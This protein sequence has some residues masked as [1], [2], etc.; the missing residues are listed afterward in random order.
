[1]EDQIC[2]GDI[3]NLEA[4][5]DRAFWE[6]LVDAEGVSHTWQPGTEPVESGFTVAEQPTARIAYPWNPTAPEAE[7]FF[8]NPAIPSIFAGIE[9]AEI[10]YRSQTFFNQLQHVWTPFSV[11][12]MLLERFATRMPQ[13]WLTAIAQQAQTVVTQTQQTVADVST[14]L[15]D[16]LVQCVRELVPGLAEDDFYV[17]ARPLAVQMRD[18]SS[19]NVVDDQIAQVPQLD[20]E[21]LSELQQARLGLAIARYAIDELQATEAA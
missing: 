18:G 19:T 13:V 11:E 4:M 21:Q 12:A 2:T 1:M 10:D 17:L 7:A 16:Q 20:W 6:A 5:V 14:K 8:S 9:D 3:G 15:A